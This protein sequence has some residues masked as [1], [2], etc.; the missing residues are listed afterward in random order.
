MFANEYIIDDHFDAATVSLNGQHILV[1]GAITD[2]GFAVSR[3]LASKGSVIIMIDRKERLM[4]PLYDQILQDGGAEPIMIAM[5]M[6]KAEPQDFEKLTAGLD[7]EIRALDGLLHLDLLAAPLTPLSLTNPANWLNCYQYV[8]MRPMMITQALLPL[9]ERAP[10]PSVLFA[11]FSAG[12]QGKAYWGPVG[13]AYAAI[14]NLSQSM[15]HEFD[16]LRVNTIDPGRVNSSIRHK[17]HPAEANSTLRAFDDP[18]V[19]EHFLF[20]FSTA[21]SGV[22]GKMLLVPDLS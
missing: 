10:N 7:G 2:L 21:A 4:A 15:A 8:V 1:T 6:A 17:Y 3:K 19:L 11:S 18:V 13:A 14:E 22:N 9:L 16:N 5:D 12:R 20:P